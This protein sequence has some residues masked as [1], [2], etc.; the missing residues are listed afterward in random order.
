M[1]PAKLT[2]S[3]FGPYAG[4]VTVDFERLGDEGLYLI[5][6]DTGA[7]KTTIFDAISFALYGVASGTDRTARSLRSDFAV[8]GAETYVELEFEH[9]GGR[10]VI[11]RNP[12]Y[13][14]PKKRGSGMATQLADATLSHEGEPPITGTRAVDK[15]IDELLGI[16]RN[17][18][19]QI[20]MIAQGDFRRLLKADTKERSAIMRKLFG[21]QPY[22]K[23]QDALAARSH[24]LE[25]QA[26]STRELLL[27]LVPTIQVTG[28]KRTGR[29]AGLVDSE[30]PDADVALALLREQGAE[31]DAELACLEAKRARGAAEVGRLSGLAERASQLER[32]RVELRGA[33]EE[34]ESARAA[35]E[36]ALE[37]V[38][39]QNGRADKRRRLADRAAVMEQELS[40][41]SE[42]ASA[43]DEERRAESDLS[44][45][46]RV[47]EGARGAL[48]R[49]DAS[50]VAA[51]DAAANLSDAPAA[52]ARAQA[53]R[54]EAARLL[55]EAR[56]TLD[57]AT[58]LARRR[59]ALPA[60]R[61]AAAGAQDALTGLGDASHD[62]A[63][64]LAR[65][66]DE[67]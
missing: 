63:E 44:K 38:D 57:G 10:Y 43:E 41:F 24:K 29:L 7:G 18:F 45:A 1:R 36:P 9:R 20:V 23:F 40:K 17:Q 47:S 48:D 33:R 28:E 54:S 35:V 60:L 32:Q 6:G 25:D 16:D 37:A 22:L 66:R 31:D 11:R 42:L 50:L 51:R 67:R 46:R 2:I 15:A 34:L 55:D 12:E 21:T 65:A 56:K 5:C 64:E 49:A 59:A 39:E 19:S 58:E 53:E 8:P 3:A 13:E 26:K 27:A 61:G 62:L 52:L 4:K 14:R 30:A